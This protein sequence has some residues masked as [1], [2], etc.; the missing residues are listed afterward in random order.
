M[1]ITSTMKRIPIPFWK[2][3]KW[4][5]RLASDE[6]HRVSDFAKSFSENQVYAKSWLIERLMMHPFVNKK[7][8]DIWILGSWYGT[9][10]VP[11]LMSKFPDIF[12]IHLVDFDEET[13]NIAERLWYTKTPFGNLIQTHCMDIN[14]DFEQLEGDLI[15]NT[16]CEHMLPMNEFD[17]KGLCAFQSNNFR[18]EIAHI[19]CVDSLEEFIEQTGIEDV[20]YSGEIPFHTYDDHH[21]RYMVI[22]E[23]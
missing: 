9:I 8:K 5:E 21:K 13:L 11:L 1:A 7:E 3:S 12:R 23:R 19:N 16:S 2:Y 22:G 17:C 10:L 6:P 20:Y 14:F 4:L 15:I 18:E